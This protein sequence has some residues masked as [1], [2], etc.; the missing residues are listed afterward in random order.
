MQR[1]NI[2]FIG[3][4]L[5]TLIL[6]GAITISK[7]NAQELT[8]HSFEKALTLADTADLPVLVDIG[9]P[10]CGWCHKMKQEV[11]PSLASELQDRFVT[12]RLNRDDHEKVHRYKGERLTSLR[13]AQELNANTVPTIV[14]LTSDGNYLLH[15]SGFIEAKELQPVLEYIATE[16][17]RHQTFQTFINQT[18]S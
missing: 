9:A 12:T 14:F 6:L 4:L 16:A 13:L 5:V 2:K 10:W 17:Y 1:N 7:L 3:S 11:Y 15:L 8:W 18:G